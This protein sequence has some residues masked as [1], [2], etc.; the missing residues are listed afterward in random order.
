VRMRERLQGV[1]GVRVSRSRVNY[2]LEHVFFLRIY[3]TP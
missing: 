3:S 2:V 1:V